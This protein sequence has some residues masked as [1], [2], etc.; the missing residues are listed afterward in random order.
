LSAFVVF[1][2]MGFYPVTPGMPAYN[3]GS[4]L[5]RKVSIDLGNG[6]RFEVE[7]IDCSRENK[8]VQSAVLNG[9][10]WNKPWFSHEDIKDGGKL[11]LTMGNRP[12]YSWGNRAEDAP[13]SAERM[14]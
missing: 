9:K 5:F 14:D 3:I 2:A 4:P 1:S 12:N 8:Y 7:A 6:K 11:T 10:P 13:P